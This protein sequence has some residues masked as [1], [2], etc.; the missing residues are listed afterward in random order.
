M[1]PDKDERAGVSD[2]V[3]PF[4]DFGHGELWRTGAL[5]QN[6]PNLQNTIEHLISKIAFSVQ[7]IMVQLVQYWNK[8]TYHHIKKKRISMLIV[9]LYIVLYIVKPIL[10]Y[11]TCKWKIQACMNHDYY[12]NYIIK[13]NLLSIYYKKNLCKETFY[14]L[15]IL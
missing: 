10:L 8:Q 14:F 7:T 4:G 11:S 1:Y 5:A 12:K 6:L 13:S 15:C 2:F 3:L 9:Y